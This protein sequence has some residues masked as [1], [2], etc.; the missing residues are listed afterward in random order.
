MQGASVL[1]SKVKCVFSVLW[2]VYIY[3]WSAKLIVP[4]L[5]YITGWASMLFWGVFPKTTVSQLYM[6]AISIVTN[7]HVCMYNV[8]I[9]IFHAIYL[10]NNHSF[11]TYKTIFILCV[12]R[13][14]IYKWTAFFYSE[15]KL[16]WL[17]CSVL[18][19]FPVLSVCMFLF[20]VLRSCFLCFSFHC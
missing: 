14:V 5:T 19:L 3:Y 11:Y 7:I 1:N 8:S 16:I 6:V 13:C 18:V 12:R 2:C 4:S 17:S 9:H 10:V 15:N 20:S